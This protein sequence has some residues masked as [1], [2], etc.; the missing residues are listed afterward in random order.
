MSTYTATIRWTRDP[1][2]DFPRGQYSRAHEWSFDGG[3]VVPA[4][5]S[6][7]IMHT[8]SDHGHSHGLLVIDADSISENE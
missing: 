8:C 5:P 4:T 3:A 7:Q 1:D 6:Y 2:T